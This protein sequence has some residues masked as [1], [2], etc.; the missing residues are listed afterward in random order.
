MFGD[1][2]DERDF[3]FAKKYHIPLK[4]SLRTKLILAGEHAAR[5]NVETMYRRGTD[6]I[7]QNEKG[8]FLLIYEE[9]PLCY[10]FVGGGIEE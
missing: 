4:Q 2:H 9:N 5:S 7:I 6:A 1:A 8:E 3:A 10:H